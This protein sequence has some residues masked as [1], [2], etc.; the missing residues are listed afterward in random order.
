MIIKY[1]LIG[2]LQVLNIETMIVLVEISWLIIFD[3]LCEIVT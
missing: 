1:L 2:L 3:H